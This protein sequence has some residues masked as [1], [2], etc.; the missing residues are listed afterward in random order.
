MS[1]ENAASSWLQSWRKG[2]RRE[3]E[4][5]WSWWKLMKVWHCAKL[6]VLAVATIAS[7]IV[8][9]VECNE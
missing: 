4:R 3:G 8:G 6:P 9:S 2:G 1:T 5:E 7:F